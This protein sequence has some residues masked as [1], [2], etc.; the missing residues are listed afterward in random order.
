MSKNKNSQIPLD[1]KHTPSLALADFIVSDANSLA[2]EHVIA[3]PNWRVP[4]SLII[5]PP[6]S[7]KSHLS[8]IW[9][10]KSNA[11]IAENQ[12]LEDLAKQGGN[13]PV[14][15]ENIDNGKFNEQA[16]FHFLNKSIRDER[17]VLITATKP[18]SQWPF[19]TND[20]KSRA[21]LA[22]SFS[23]DTPDDVQLSQMFA[24]LFDDRQIK[25]E[26]KIISYLVSRMERSAA[27][28]VALVAKMDMIALSRNKPITIAVAKEALSLKEKHEQI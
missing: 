15:L 17:V 1:F 11:I 24:K 28:V 20:V 5:G 7:G 13:E 22:A 27:E 16:V 21:R 9:I 18:I 2:F 10:E 3:Y 6:K 8:R 12:M 26:P 25:V 23:V 4:M 19:I 14:L